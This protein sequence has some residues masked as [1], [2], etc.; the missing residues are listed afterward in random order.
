MK[1]IILI[2][3]T[4]IFILT[5]SAYSTFA[6]MILVPLEQPSIQDGIDAAVDGD[7]VL[8]A[9]GTYIENIDFAGKLITLQS[10]A[11]ADV[12]TIDGD[13]NGSVVTFSSG[14]TEAAAIDGFTITNGTGTIDGP[15][16]YGG[17]IYCDSSSP[18]IM[19]CTISFNGATCGCGIYCN[20]ASPEIAK[21]TISSNGAYSSGG[22]IYCDSSSPR[23]INC[24]ILEN[25]AKL[26]PG[27][28]GGGGGI[29]CRDATATIINCTL[30]GNS[31][32][33]GGGIYCSHSSFTVVTNCILWGNLASTGPEIYV[34]TP[35]DPAI[36]SVRDSDVEGGEADTY[37][38]TGCLLNWLAGNIESDPLFVGGDDY[39]LTEGSPCIDA[40]MDAGVYTDMDG[41]VRPS[42]AWFDIGADEFIFGCVITFIRHRLNDNQYL[43]I[44]ESPNVVGGEINPLLA[45]DTWIG[46]IGMNNEITH[47]TGGDIDGDGTD[48]LIFIRHKINDNQYLNIYEGPT[49]VGGDINPL[50]ASDTWIGNVGTNSE[51]THM[52]AGD[53]DD[54]GTDE[55]IFIRHMTN[56]DQY[57]NIYD[58]PT[59]IGSDINPLIASDTWIGKI[60]TNNE[61]THMAAG[62]ID[63][64]GAKELIFIR[65]RT[66]GNQY[67]NIYDAPTAVA[68]DINPLIA[69]DL[70]IGNIGSS[71]EI[72]HMAAGDTDGDGTDELV[73]IRHRINDNQYLNIYNN[74]TV[75]GG[76]INP[77]IASDLWIGNIGT[78]NEI[79]HMTMSR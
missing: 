19:N 75:V 35:S 46:N 22:G 47:M 68:G 50:I 40:G 21:C 62:D 77:L 55:L 60:G 53:T 44:Y 1:S 76:D 13:D 26:G 43:N 15:W 7:T 41:D 52:A 69:S 48:E 16:S 28:G 78:S 66:N 31:S 71:N 57:L 72:T 18:M 74:P 2:P 61:I 4:T 17:G 38:A 27:Y 12:T 29:F 36:L 51:I 56:D 63:G 59:V 54:D 3:I 8:V 20:N 49:V 45:S 23:I 11:G 65:H 39:H 42:G 25:F 67:L 6:A 24:T 73:F 32:A 5:L 33:Y 37:V 58:A 9:P 10:E 14:E 34:G 79:T 30:S 64:D 70:W